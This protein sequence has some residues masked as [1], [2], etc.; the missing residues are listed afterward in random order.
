MPLH[1]NVLAPLYPLLC[2]YCPT[3]RVAIKLHVLLSAS[4]ADGNSESCEPSIS[5]LIQ[6]ERTMEFAEGLR[7][8]NLL[9]RRVVCTFCRFVV[10]FMWILSSTVAGEPASLSDFEIHKQQL[11][12]TTFLRPPQGTTH[13]QSD[14]LEVTSAVPESLQA[15]SLR[16]LRFNPIQGK[17]RAT[18]FFDIPGEG[19]IN[20]F[21]KR[22][23][24]S[25]PGSSP[26]DCTS[27]CE[28]CTPCKPVHV[29][30]QPGRNSI[31]L[32]E[33]YPEAWRCK[34]KN[35]LFMP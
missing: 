18:Q 32:M 8:H 31:G 12:M 16:P 35:K 21:W 30:I 20:G 3:T 1:Y 11:H 15:F 33:Y 14:E 25:G 13:S 9:N 29:P 28:N 4:P 26:P 10:P 23:I 17:D 27:R 6:S 2:P 19:R 34:C 24:L 22:R 7:Y 5:S